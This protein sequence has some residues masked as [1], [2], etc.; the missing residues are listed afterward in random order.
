M[1][2]WLEVKEK[3]ICLDNYCVARTAIESVLE[4]VG[5]LN[6]QVEKTVEEHVEKLGKL[7]DGD[8]PY[9]FTMENLKIS[10]YDIVFDV[11]ECHLEGCEG[12]VVASI[13]VEGD[14][15]TMR[16]IVKTIMKNMGID[17]YVKCE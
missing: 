4:K 10:I 17:K 6:T 13:H 8:D 9:T 5:V 15:N 1:G 3:A 14:I 16:K 2:L 11:V 12:Y 7:I